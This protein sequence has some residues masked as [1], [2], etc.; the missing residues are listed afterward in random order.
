[1][2]ATPPRSE[3]ASIDSPSYNIIIIAHTFI[4]FLT[5]YARYVKLAYWGVAS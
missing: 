2:L 4:E 5:P 1:M 3:H